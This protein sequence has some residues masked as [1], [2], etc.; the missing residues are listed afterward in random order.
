MS[1]VSES[2]DEFV[3]IMLD[4]TEVV[5][6]LTGSMAKEMAVLLYAM[7]KDSN[8]KTKGQTRLNNILKSNSNLKVFTIRKEDFQDFKKQAKRYGVLY[9]ALYKKRDKN[10]DGVIDIL[11]REEDAVRVNRITERFNLT[12]VA[13]IEKEIPDIEE[14]QEIPK[15]SEIVQEKKEVQA[16]NTSEELLNKLLKKQNVKEENENSTP[17][18][19]SNTERET[20]L[21][22]L[23]NPNE[24]N[25]ITKKE[26]KPSIRETLNLIKKEQEEKEKLK[27]KE[28]VKENQNHGN[29]KETK[30]KQSKKK[31][32]KKERKRLYEQNK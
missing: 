18:S 19:I 25:E 8:K 31:K 27:V 11:V 15:S 28:Q 7:S 6:K 5:L 12:T 17:S 16:R 9:T 22:N 32:R 20:R 30:H 1:T 13:N 2:A 24:K 4:G 3:K 29:I 21:E 10:N 14:R 23:L 26:E